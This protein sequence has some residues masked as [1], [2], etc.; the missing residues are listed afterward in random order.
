MTPHTIT[1]HEALRADLDAIRAQDAENR[2]ESEVGAVSLAAPIRGANGQV[3]AAL[4]LAGPAD[5]ID[6]HRLPL[7]HATME[8]AALAS[9]RLGDRGAV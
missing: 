7:A 8:A 6:P 9:R 4:S 3:I 2:Q 5:R 1:G